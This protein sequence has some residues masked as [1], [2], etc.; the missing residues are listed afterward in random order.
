MR[1]RFPRIPVADKGEKLGDWH[2]MTPGEREKYVRDL[3]KRAQ[4]PS[5]S[6]VVSI[7]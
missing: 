4:R 3:K 2:R 5:F 1:S 7:F 6:P